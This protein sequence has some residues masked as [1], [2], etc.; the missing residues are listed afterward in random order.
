MSKNVGNIFCYV[1]STKTNNFPVK[2][3]VRY[4]PDR[5][6]QCREGQESKNDPISRSKR[7]T[8]R[9]LTQ[10]S[11]LAA[12]STPVLLSLRFGFAW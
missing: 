10:K 4:L 5:K 2:R 11:K 7:I 6:S 8:S 1:D 3:P 9:Y 12:V